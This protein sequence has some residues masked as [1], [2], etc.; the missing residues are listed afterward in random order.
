MGMSFLKRLQ[1]TI[2]VLLVKRLPVKL[3]FEHVWLN[4][5]VENKTNPSHWCLKGKKT[6]FMVGRF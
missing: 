5:G 1:I 4:Q 6:R 3:G 2:Q